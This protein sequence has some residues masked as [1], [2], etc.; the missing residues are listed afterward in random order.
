[1]LYYDLEEDARDYQGLEGPAWEGSWSVALSSSADGGM[2]FGPAVLVDSGLVPPERVMLIYTMPPPALAVDPSGSLFAA[3]HDARNGDWDVFLSRSDDG[4]AT[5]GK[6]RRLNDDRVGNGRHQYM[7][8]LSISEGG[9]LDAIFYD[10]RA[11]PDNL[12]NGTYFTYS[13]DGGA[14]FSKNLKLT[15]DSSHSEIGVRYA[16]PSALG[17]VEFGSRIALSSGPSSVLAA[18]TD[19]RNL[20]IDSFSQDI[21]AT[22]VDLAGPLGASPA[23]WALALGAALLLGG[24]VV[25]RGRRGRRGRAAPAVEAPVGATES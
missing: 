18:W 4:G 15:A 11:D 7:P 5:W 2:S 3:W 14:T 1:V 24:L 23:R 10:R 16:V 12:R 17:L 13:D 6:P 21:F 25:A 20:D 8:R 19:T 22:R 9:R